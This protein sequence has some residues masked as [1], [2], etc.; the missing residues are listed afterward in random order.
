MI[1]RTESMFV[2]SLS[3]HNRD[4]ATTAGAE[5]SAGR[6]LQ[7]GCREVVAAR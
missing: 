4:P 1:I 2:V 6:N 3:C 7:F 5:V